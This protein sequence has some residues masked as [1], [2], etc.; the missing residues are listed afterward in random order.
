MS[1]RECRRDLILRDAATPLLSMRTQAFG[2]HAEE[3][4]RGVSKYE[5][6]LLLVSGDSFSGGARQG[7]RD[8]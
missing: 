2:P 7:A 6:A 1:V 4:R 3:P 5:V 8:E